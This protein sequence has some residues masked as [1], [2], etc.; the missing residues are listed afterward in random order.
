MIY[1]LILNFLKK[2]EFEEWKEYKC[3]S[4]KYDKSNLE[5]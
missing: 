2:L 3:S 5:K 1:F 4:R